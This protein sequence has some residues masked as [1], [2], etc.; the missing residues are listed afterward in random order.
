MYI[1][2]VGG[3]ATV[4]STGR[5]TTNTTRQNDKVPGRSLRPGTPDEH[6]SEMR[7]NMNDS[8]KFALGDRVR[9]AR[10][11]DGPWPR[12]FLGRTGTIHK[13]EGTWRWVKFDEPVRSSGSRWMLT[14][15]LEA[16][17]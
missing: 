7:F 10:T 4:L 5:T 14:T 1:A 17:R 15:E 11:E 12:R 16:V 9:V 2:I 3:G 6:P 8:P 13:I